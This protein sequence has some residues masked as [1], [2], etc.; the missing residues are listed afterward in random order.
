MLGGV[1]VEAYPVYHL[2]NGGKLLD[3]WEVEIFA[4]R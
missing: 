3:L 1:E 4:A 2:E